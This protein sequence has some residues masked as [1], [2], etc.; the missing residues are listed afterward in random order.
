MC[1]EEGGVQYQ[2]ERGGDSWVR[3]ALDVME[4]ERDELC[5]ETFGAEHICAVERNEM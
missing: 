5:M 4:R 3:G 2:R 1:E